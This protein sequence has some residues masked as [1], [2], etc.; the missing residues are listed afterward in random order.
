MLFN[1]NQ[2]GSVLGDKDDYQ[3]CKPIATADFGKIYKAVKL[4]DLPENEYKRVSNISVVYTNLQCKHMAANI[5][6]VEKSRR[7]S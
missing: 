4:E 5:Y 3:R 1:R 2:P 6:D 7:L